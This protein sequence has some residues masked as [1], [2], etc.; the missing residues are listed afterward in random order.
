MFVDFYY[1]VLSIK[2]RINLSSVGEL[3]KVSALVVIQGNPLSFL[4]IHPGP[5]SPPGSGIIE[6]RASKPS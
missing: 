4:A 6:Y 3:S 2:A 1:D 5:P